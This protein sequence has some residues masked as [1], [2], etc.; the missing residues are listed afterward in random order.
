MQSLS[1]WSKQACW[2]VAMMWSSLKM[3][4]GGL[5]DTTQKRLDIHL[6]DCSPA[7][8][9]QLKLEKKKNAKARRVWLSLSTSNQG[10]KGRGFLF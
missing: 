3:L 8:S 6:L 9:S 7:Q 10:S 4:T 1:E 5:K 2:D